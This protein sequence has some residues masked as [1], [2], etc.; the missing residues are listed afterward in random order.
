[1]SIA[2]SAPPTAYHLA[3]AS[4]GPAQMLHFQISSPWLIPPTSHNP[5]RTYY[6]PMEGVSLATALLHLPKSRS[7]MANAIHL[8]TA[9]GVCNGSYMS[10]V[11]PDF[12]TVAW[13]LE[14]ISHTT[15][16]VMASPMSLAHPWRPMP[17]VQFSKDSTLYSWQSQDSVHSTELLLG[18]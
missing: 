5:V 9:H 3:F 14:D 16:C 1:M 7:G 10:A 6:P 11:S 18:Q 15:I 2:T 4:P 12:A 17:I 13:L 8:G